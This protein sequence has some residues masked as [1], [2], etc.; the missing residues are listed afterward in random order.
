MGKKRKN[1]SL[2]ES[3]ILAGHLVE[4]S[5]MELADLENVNIETE[6]AANEEVFGR[7]VCSTPS[8]KLV[9]LKGTN[10]VSLSI[11]LDAIQ[12]LTAKV[13]KTHG[14]VAVSCGK[15]RHTV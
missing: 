10:E 4:D 5:C 11:L 2:Q 1:Q 3:A 9:S 15:T 8:K 7:P 14:K 12:K 6:I 13:D